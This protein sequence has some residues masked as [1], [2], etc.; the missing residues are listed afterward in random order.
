MIEIMQK[1]RVILFIG[2]ITICILLFSGCSKC[3][4]GDNACYKFW[5]GLVPDET[6]A[7]GYRALT[8]GEVIFGEKETSEKNKKF[9]TD[10]G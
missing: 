9:L 2:F 6:K 8:I 3:Q 1:I 10:P 7:S 4:M 5:Y